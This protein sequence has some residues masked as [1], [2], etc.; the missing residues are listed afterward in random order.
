MLYLLYCKYYCIVAT[1]QNWKLPVIIENCAENKKMYN[2]FDGV[3]GL[4]L[5]TAALFKIVFT[6]ETEPEYISSPIYCAVQHSG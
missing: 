2:S 6:V 5:S 4:L 1:Q 3:V